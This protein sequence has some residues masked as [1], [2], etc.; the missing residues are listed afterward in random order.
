MIFLIVT[1]ILLLGISTYLGY[2][3][4]YMAGVIADIQE[5]DDEASSY[6]ESLEIT[7]RFMYSKIVQAHETMARIDSLGAFAAEDEV[8]TTFDMLKEIIESL[9]EEL[10]DTGE[11]K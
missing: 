5:Q 6:I 7:N 11:K 4:W 2:R 8:G 10:D 9:K 3:V 1:S